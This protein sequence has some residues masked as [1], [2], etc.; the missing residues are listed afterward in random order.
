[1][2]MC[3]SRPLIYTGPGSVEWR[4]VRNEMGTTVAT[5]TAGVSGCQTALD[6]F[7]YKSK[8]KTDQH[9]LQLRHFASLI[10]PPMF[11]QPPNP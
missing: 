7:E 6:R 1:M 8:P 4:T 11:P 2:T 3:Y 5:T 10:C 9:V